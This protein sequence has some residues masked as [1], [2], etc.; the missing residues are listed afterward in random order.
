MNCFTEEKVHDGYGYNY[1]RKRITEDKLVQLCLS[2]S[3]KGPFDNTRCYV[4]TTIK[5]LIPSLYP[6]R[7]TGQTRNIVIMALDCD[8]Q[9]ASIAA[10]RCLRREGIHW[11]S[12]QSSPGK[13]WFITD[14][15]APFREVHAKMKTIVGVDVDYV[16][17]CG[18][19]KTCHLRAHPDIDRVPDVANMDLGGI[20]DSRVRAWLNDFDRLHHRMQSA[21]ENIRLKMALDKGEIYTIASDPGFDI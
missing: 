9:E 18:R 19:Y 2:K 4:S 20:E 5:R 7:L 6:L 8:S 10:A 21:L 11:A 17:Q 1:R 3:T 16:A 14:F 12:V 13:F 15:V